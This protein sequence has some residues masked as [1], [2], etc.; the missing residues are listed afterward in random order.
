MSAGLVV[1]IDI[2]N[3]KLYFRLSNTTK[4]PGPHNMESATDPVTEEETDNL[5]SQIYNFGL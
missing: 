1:P 2:E 4:G 5:A 3:S